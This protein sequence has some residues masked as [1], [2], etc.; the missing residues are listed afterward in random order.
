MGCACSAAPR[1]PAPSPRRGPV[2]SLEGSG[3]EYPPAARASPTSFPPVTDAHGHHP[4]LSDASHVPSTPSLLPTQLRG[5]FSALGVSRARTPRT[6]TALRCRLRGSPLV[7]AVVLRAR[8]GRSPSSLCCKP[9][10]CGASTSLLSRP[11]ALPLPPLMARGSRPRERTRPE[12]PWQPEEVWALAWRHVGRT[13]LLARAQ[14]L[15]TK[16]ATAIL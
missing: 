15:R 10:S 11:A 1:S 3:G 8:H 5:P 14:A 7:G 6:P 16:L 2:L 9:A 4:R 12:C 13:T